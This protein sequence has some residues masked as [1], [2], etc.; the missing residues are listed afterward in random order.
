MLLKSKDV[1]PKQFFKYRLTICNEDT[2]QYYLRDSLESG[3]TL[4]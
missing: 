4:W 1:I 2:I 3:G